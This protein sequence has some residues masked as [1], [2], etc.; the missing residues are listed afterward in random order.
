MDGNTDTSVNTDNANNNGGGFAGWGGFGNTDDSD[1]TGGG[2][3][4]WDDFSFGAFDVFSN[5]EEFKTKNATM[6]VELAG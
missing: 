2:F 4:G 1:N 3:G 5:K 6:V